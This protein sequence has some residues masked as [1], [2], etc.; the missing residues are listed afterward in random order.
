MLKHI[1]TVICLFACCF[2]V[3]AN[4]GRDI[5]TA[6]AEPGMGSLPGGRGMI[7]G[8]V[9]DKNN[10]GI[11]EVAVA[12]RQKVYAVTD[13]NGNYSFSLSPGTYQLSFTHLQFKTAS[14]QVT[15]N[16]V[17]RPSFP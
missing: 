6:Q 8:V 12:I 2:I 17:K 7:Q 15:V 14:G 16:E 10:Q 3:T 13:A 4:S 5:V 9:T 1:F 11:P